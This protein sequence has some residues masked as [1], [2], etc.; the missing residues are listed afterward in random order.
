MFDEDSSYLARLLVL[1]ILSIILMTVDHR[2]DYLVKFKGFLTIFSYPVQYIA[3]LPGEFLQLI[4]DSLTSQQS[5]LERNLRLQKEN[6]LLK[7]QVQQF[8]ALQSE[9]MRLRSLLQSSRK[10]SDDMLIAETIAVAMDPYQRQIVVNKGI[11]QGVYKGQPIVDAYGI[12]GQISEPGVLT[13]TAILITDPSHAIP[14]QVNRNGLRAVV[15][16]MGIANQVAIPYLPNNSDIKV[17]DLL[18]SSGLGGRFPEGYPVARVTSV[19]R[20]LG[21]P[22]AEILAKPM[23]HMERSR[24]V[25]LVLKH[26][27]RYL[28][29]D[30]MIKKANDQDEKQNKQE[31]VASP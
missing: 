10:L 3:S 20:N 25:L 15:Y 5:L 14:V 22:F 21:Q 24:E 26:K 17:G 18:V 19:K 13:S 11:S 16:G 2:S 29:D 8:T 28:V 1:S 30:G 9:N 27:D 4:D 7:A 6:L 31:D 12:M 23:A